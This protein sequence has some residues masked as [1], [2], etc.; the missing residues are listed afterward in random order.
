M[1]KYK[2]PIGTDNF[3]ELVSIDP[4]SG[5]ETYFII[6]S[7]REVGLGKPDALIIP[8]NKENSLGIILE[9]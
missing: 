8:K 5:K 4:I 3:G 7:N 6:I 9:F 1:R 2:L